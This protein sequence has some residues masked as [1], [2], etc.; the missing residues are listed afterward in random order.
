PPLDQSHGESAG[1]AQ[2]RI[3]RTLL[4]GF[5]ELD[6]HVS[7]ADAEAQCATAPGELFRVA[8]T[9]DSVLHLEHAR[10]WAS[11]PDLNA[12]VHDGFPF[13][14]SPDLAQSVAVLS[15]K[16]QA[17]EI[18]LLLSIAAHAG[19]VTGAA[20]SLAVITSEQ[21][22]AAGASFDKDVLV[23]GTLESNTALRRW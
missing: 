18:A 12:F 8:I 9:P 1:R 17:Q 4:H 14:R 7:Y 6:L 2:L 11:L 5:N 13:T 20:G 10:L 19:S 22:F 23:I 15:Q 16:P 3:H 21:L